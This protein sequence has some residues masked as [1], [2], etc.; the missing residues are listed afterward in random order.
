M[1]NTCHLKNFADAKMPFD[2]HIA[3]YFSGFKKKSLV[4]ISAD[5]D[6]CDPAIQQQI[7]KQVKGEEFELFRLL[8]GMFYL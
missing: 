7:Q 2:G 3:N 1:P 6:M 8:L 4:K 5:F